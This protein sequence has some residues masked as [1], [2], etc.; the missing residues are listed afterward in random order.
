MLEE[1]LISLSKIGIG[2]LCYH[3]NA[4]LQICYEK[5]NKPSSRTKLHS[6][7]ADRLISERSRR[8][9]GLRKTTNPDNSLAHRTT[10]LRSRLKVVREQVEQWE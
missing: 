2:E 4:V 10:W 6:H 1:L 8:P 5:N 7:E 3:D 9:S